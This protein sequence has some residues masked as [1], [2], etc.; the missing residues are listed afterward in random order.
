[1]VTFVLPNCKYARTVIFSVFYH[2]RQEFNLLRPRTD[3]AHHAHHA[4]GPTIQ[5]LVILIEQS[6]IGRPAHAR[7]FRREFPFGLGGAPAHVVQPVRDP[8]GPMH[9]ALG[10]VLALGSVLQ[11]VALPAAEIAPA[12]ELADPGRI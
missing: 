1:M 2:R 9:G 8:V 3:P 7:G 11:P 6:L 12:I 5:Q 4:D 10:R